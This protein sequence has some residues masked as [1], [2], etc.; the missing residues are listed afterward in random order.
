VTIDLA[1]PHRGFTLTGT[2]GASPLVLAS[3][4][5]GRAY[6]PAFMAQTRLTLQQ[7]RRAEDAYVDELVAGGPPRGA[8]LVAAHFGRAWLDLNR[9]A[10]ELDPAMFIDAIAPHPDQT[11]ERVRAGLGVLPRIAAHGLDI[12]AA[13]VPLAQARARLAA[14]HE[15][16]H[17]A[18]AMLL[19]E[20]RRRHGAAVLID[21]HSMPTPLM[22]GAPQIVIGDLYGR[23]AAPQLIDLIERLFTAAGLRV[24]RNDPYAGGYTTQAH[25]RP[26]DGIH[27]VQIEIDRALYMDP[28]RLVRNRGFARIAAVMTQLVARLL[29]SVDGLDLGARREAAE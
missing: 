15:P 20:A 28:A 25:A 6:P 5:S 11:G 18:I 27:A 24:A 9:S 3:P 13:R 8:P 14:V 26:V 16:Y 12:Y 23:S 21:C 7:L 29:A 10:D 4:H 22:R 1:L 2:P 19:V 17:A